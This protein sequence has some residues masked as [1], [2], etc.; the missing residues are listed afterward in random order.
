MHDPLLVEMLFCPLLFYGSA[1][2]HDMD[3][4]QFCIMFRSIFLEGLARPLAGRAAD[5][6]ETGAQVQGAGGR[7]AAARRREPDVDR[8][9]AGGKP[10]CSTTARNCRPQ[11]VI[12][13]AGWVETMRLCDDVSRP[14]D[15]RRG[16]LS[17]VESMSV[18]NAQ[19]HDL[20]HDRTIVFFNDSTTFHWEK[21]DDLVD[22]RSGVICSPNNFVYDE[23]LGRGND[24][25]HGPGQFRPLGSPA[26]RGLSAGEAGWYDRMVASAVRFVPDFR[27]AVID[28]RH[29]HARP[30]SAAYTGHDNGAVYGAPEKRYDGT[31]HLKNLFICGNRS[32]VRGHRRRDPQ[33]HR[34]GQLGHVLQ[35]TFE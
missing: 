29:V 13:S 30:R 5:P 15:A 3:F 6:E 32:G 24:P 20:G 14:I 4:G 22:V 25:D 12:S 18:L 31:T 23:P 1:G 11:R 35:G 17:F 27:C 10:S 28:T 33:R 9:R 8:R 19:P 2:E 16:S 26:G 7:A 34:H 21:P